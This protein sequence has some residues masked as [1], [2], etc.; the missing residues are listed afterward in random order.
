MAPFTVEVIRSRRRTRTVGARLVGSVLEVSV[1]C[2]MSAAAAERWAAVMSTRFAR[3]ADASLVDLDR[4]AAELA[5]RYDLPRTGVDPL[6]RRRCAPAGARCTPSTRRIRISIRLA[7]YPDWV[8]D[9]VIVH[10]LAH[11]APS[12]SRPAFWRLV[13]R[14]PRAERA[15][16][17]LMAKSGDAEMSDDPR[18]VSATHAS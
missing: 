9:Y 6:G 13:D 14:Y 16:G 11:L 18:L 10:E 4:R 7:P 8:R 17:Y 15:R 3:K 5:R 2:W 1:P 12:G